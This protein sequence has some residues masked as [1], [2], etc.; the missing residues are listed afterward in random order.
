[1]ALLTEAVLDK[2]APRMV[3]LMHPR[4]SLLPVFEWLSVFAVFE[5]VIFFDEVNGQ[6]LL[7][8]TAL[9][10][11]VAFSREARQA[12][13][14]QVLAVFSFVNGLAGEEEATLVPV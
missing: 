7:A 13:Y 8:P 14:V 5:L 4:V 9:L 12:A 11:V 10:D 2:L 6:L 3:L 1:M